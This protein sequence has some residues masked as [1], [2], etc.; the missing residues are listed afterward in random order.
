MN[1]V[2]KYDDIDLNSK[3]DQFGNRLLFQKII[4]ISF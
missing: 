2:H 1:I 3:M 4:L